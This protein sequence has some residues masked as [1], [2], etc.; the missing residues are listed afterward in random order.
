MN[1]QIGSRKKSSWIM[2]K[3]KAFLTHPPHLRSSLTSFIVYIL[4]R[5]HQSTFCS[6]SFIIDAKLNRDSLD[7]VVFRF[8][9]LL[10]VFSRRGAAHYSSTQVFSV[11][12]RSSSIYSI[13]YDSFPSI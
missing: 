6:Y 9:S 10:R 13:H 8:F 1:L 4:F 7:Y 11:H 5:G 12:W 2:C 3:P